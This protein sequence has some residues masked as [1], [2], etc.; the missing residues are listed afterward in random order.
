MDPRRASVRSLLAGLPG[1]RP[2]TELPGPGDLLRLAGRAVGAVEQAVGLVPRLVTVVGQVETLM[3]RVTSL[4]E[5]IERTDDRADDLVR[6]T[7]A[8]IDGAEQSVRRTD[9]VIDTAAPLVDR[10][11]VVLGDAEQLVDRAAPLLT[12]VQPVLERLL[13]IASRIADT[14]SPDE[15]DA[16]VKLIDQ[17]PDL[18]AHLDADIVPILDTFGTVAPDVR[19][20]LDIVRELNEMLAS[21]P[22]L[23][24]VKQRIEEQQA[25]EDDETRLARYTADEVPPSAPAR[26]ELVAD[27]G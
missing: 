25:A 27:V 7:A 16:V 19:D 23:G 12:A 21:V 4:L 6:R 3:G 20:L 9:A 24:K 2:L 10:T 5:R 8:V 18:V 11:G 13:P 15:V 22:G 26:K 17:L 1:L 14:T